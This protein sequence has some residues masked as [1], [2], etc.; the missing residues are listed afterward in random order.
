MVCSASPHSQFSKRVTP[1]LCMDER[2]HPA[3]VCRQ[4]SLTQAV[5][6]KFILTGL[7]LVPGIKTQSMDVFSKYSVFQLWFVHS[8]AQMPNLARLF[9]RFCTAGRNGCLDLV[10]FGEHLRTHLKNHTRY[11]QGP[12]IHNTPRRVSLPVSK[13]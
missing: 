4:L 11:D 8:E 6:G 12:E 5:W 10:S 13:A 2:N 3:P 1:H 9:K 7:A